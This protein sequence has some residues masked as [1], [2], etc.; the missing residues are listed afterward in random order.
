MAHI[1]FSLS[2]NDFVKLGGMCWTMTIPGIFA[3]S[4][5]KTSLMASVPPVDAPI[6]IT[7]SV[8]SLRAEYESLGSLVC[9]LA[10]WTFAFAAAFTFSI[11]SAFISSIPSY[12]FECGFG[13][14]STAPASKASSV[15]LAPFWVSEETITTGVGMCV[16]SFFKKVIPSI[17]GISTS[18]HTTSGRSSTIL[19]LAT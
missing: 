5:V 9:G 15:V 19:S 7:L 2:A 12:M 13:T 16:I 18:R 8:V 14:K 6:A 17:L 11:I 10:L 3:G 1:S 4:L